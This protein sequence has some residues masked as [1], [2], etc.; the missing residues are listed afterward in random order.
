MGGRWGGEGGR[1][2]QRGRLRAYSTEERMPIR[3]LWI[4]PTLDLCLNVFKQHTLPH[5]DR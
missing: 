2:T 4:V 3:V 5:K 1:E